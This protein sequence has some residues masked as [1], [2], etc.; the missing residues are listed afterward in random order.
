LMSEC[1][2]FLRLALYEGIDPNAIKNASDWPVV[3]LARLEYN[4]I[5]SEISKQFSRF[6]NSPK[7]MRFGLS[8]FRPKLED[9]VWLRLKDLRKILCL[10]QKYEH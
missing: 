10:L 9:H 7:F 1:L 2:P 3:E 5:L 6:L 8:V 4:A